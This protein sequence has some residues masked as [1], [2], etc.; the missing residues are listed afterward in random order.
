MNIRNFPLL[1]AALSVSLLGCQKPPPPVPDPTYEYKTVSYEAT[2]TTEAGPSSLD[3]NVADLNKLGDE[4][5]EVVSVT[6]V[7]ETRFHNFGKDEY[8]TG[9]RENVRTKS[10]TVLLRRKK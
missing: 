10:A 7:T 4:R 6:P 2:A 1:V 8:V 9:I 3:I 5:W